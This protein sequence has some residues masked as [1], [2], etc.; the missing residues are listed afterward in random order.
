[1]QKTLWIY[2]QT[3]GVFQPFCLSLKNSL[4][5]GK[6]QISPILRVVS[7]IQKKRSPAQK[8]PSSTFLEMNSKKIK[9]FGPETH[10]Y[11]WVLRLKLLTSQIVCRQTF[12]FG[13]KVFVS[14]L[15]KLQILCDT[16]YVV[17]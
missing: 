17:L 9:D 6:P 7:K 4:Q 8:P 16:P 3:S 13:K 1:M 15:E 12:R 14:L 2:S 5:F 11:L 10:N